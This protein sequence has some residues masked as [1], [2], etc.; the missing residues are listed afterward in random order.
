M[1]RENVHVRAGD[2]VIFYDGFDKEGLVLEVAPSGTRIKIEYSRDR[3][4]WFKWTCVREL[5]HPVA[6]K[7]AFWTKRW[8]L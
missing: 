4:Y 2:R 6:P 5:L 8:K 1:A 7:R 3:I